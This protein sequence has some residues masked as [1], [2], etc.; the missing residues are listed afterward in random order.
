M[1]SLLKLFPSMVAIG[2]TKMVIVVRMDLKMGQ[3]KVATQCAHAAVMLYNSASRS[4]RSEL[5]NWLVNGQPKIVLRISDNCKTTLKSLYQQARENKL[6][7]CLIYD[8]GRTQL[9]KGTLTALGIGPN[10]KENIDILTKQ[11]KL[12]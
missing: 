12:L 8:A 4:F 3:G 1:N 7:A 2:E 6:N 11:F 5:R 10:K 9:Q